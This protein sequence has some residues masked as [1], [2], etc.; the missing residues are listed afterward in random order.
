MI[1]F[2]L[3]WRLN[4]KDARF[5]A[6]HFGLADDDQGG[7]DTDAGYAND[8]AAA[9][10]YALSHRTCHLNLHQG[11]AGYSNVHDLRLA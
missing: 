11:G 7:Y 8:S 1:C 2:V 3:F 9:N 4:S 6:P 10:I 5:R